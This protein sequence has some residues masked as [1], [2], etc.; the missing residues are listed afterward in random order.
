MCCPHH[1]GASTDDSFS[2]KSLSLQAHAGEMVYL[3]PDRLLFPVQSYWLLHAAQLQ[4]QVQT[5]QQVEPVLQGQ[6]LLLLM[7]V[8]SCSDA[9]EHSLL[10]VSLRLRLHLLVHQHC[11][12]A[13]L[14]LHRS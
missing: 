2:N 10:A 12:V 5:L 7:A 6:D 4:G 13:L 3:A 1:G 11:P 9:G 8:L 14:L